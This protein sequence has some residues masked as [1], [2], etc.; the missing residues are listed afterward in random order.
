MKNADKSR[1]ARI[2]FW[3]V[4]LEYRLQAGLFSWN[5]RAEA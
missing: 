5:R 2:A 4:R 3:R 1:R